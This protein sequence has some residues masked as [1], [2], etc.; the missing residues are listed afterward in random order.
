MADPKGDDTFE[1][2]HHES[3]SI[4]PV[5][6]DACLHPEIQD[7]ESRGVDIWTVL[8]CVVC[9]ICHRLVDARLELIQLAAGSC[10][11]VRSLPFLLRSPGC[12]PLEHQCRHWTINAN[13][14]DRD[15]L[16]FGC[17]CGYSYCGTLQ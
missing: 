10:F 8:A 13:R 12:H 11:H 4:T 14:M 16:V 5:T 1:N 7:Y 15:F 9:V 3:V 17:G 6:R 2:T